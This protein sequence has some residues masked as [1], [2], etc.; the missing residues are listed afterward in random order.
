MRKQIVDSIVVANKVLDKKRKQEEVAIQNIVGIFKGSINFC[1][2]TYLDMPR[3]KKM[4]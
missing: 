1:E 4:D 3:K 2:S